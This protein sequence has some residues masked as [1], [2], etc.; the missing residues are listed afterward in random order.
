MNREGEIVPD[1]HNDSRIP[2]DFVDIVDS[3]ALA[4][5][6]TIGPHGE[7]QSTPVW[8]LWDGQRVR[9]TQVEGQQKLRNLRRDP[10]V[11][12]SMAAPNNPGRNLEIR[13]RVEREEPD[14]HN[15]LDRQLSRKYL[16]DE[17]FTGA[18]GDHVTLVIEPLHVTSFDAATAAG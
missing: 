6:A 9:I 13:G 15:D 3:T 2:P 11:A 10:R 7:P 4:H 16:G 12:L 14:P 18:P 8:F 5:V 17:S 1:D